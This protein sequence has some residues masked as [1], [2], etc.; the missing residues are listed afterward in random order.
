MFAPLTGTGRASAALRV[1]GRGLRRLVR[2]PWWREV[3][4]IGVLYGVYELSR[5]FGDVDVGSAFANGHEIL[6][7]ERLWHLDPERMLNQTLHQAKFLAVAASYFYSLMHY[8]VTP[9]VLIW[10]Y[11][12]HRDGYGFARTALALSTAVGLVGYLVLPTAP[13]RMID[14]SGLR[15]ILA[16]TQG[17]GWWSDDGSVPR[18][19]AGLTNQF[20]AMPSLHVGWAVWSGA[21]IAVYA[22]RRWVRALGI[23]YPVITTLVVMATGNHYLLDAVAGALTMA[24]GAVLAHA[25]PARFVTVPLGPGRTG[26]HLDQAGPLLPRSISSSLSTSISD[27]ELRALAD[28]EPEIVAEL[29]AEPPGRFCRARP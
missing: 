23:A 29:A 28:W 14:S 19:M 21:L 3:V 17:Y 1:C 11:R 9:A 20:A 12:R 10:M 5:G 22:R 18:G 27:D 15:D 6:R 8:L 25:L 4:L 24:V 13:P 2:T 7:L 26:P 16:D